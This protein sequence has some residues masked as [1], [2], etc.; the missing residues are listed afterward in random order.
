M[1]AADGR[2]Y[3]ELDATIASQPNWGG[4][5][6]NCVTCLH[7]FRATSD[8]ITNKTI[9]VWRTPGNAIKSH[10][11]VIVETQCVCGRHAECQIDTLN[12]CSKNPHSTL[13]L[14]NTRQ[15]VPGAA[16]PFCPD[17]MYVNT[18]SPSLTVILSRMPCGCQIRLQESDTHRSPGIGCAWPWA[19]FSLFVQPNH[20]S[21]WGLNQQYLAKC[22]F[23]A[24]L[25]KI[26]HD[27]TTC[28]NILLW[29][30]SKCHRNQH[31]W[32]VCSEPPPAFSRKGGASLFAS[33]NLSAG[34][35]QWWISSRWLLLI[36]RKPIRNRN[37]PLTRR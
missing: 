1:V 18:P 34:C 12:L 24:G 22:L 31:S 14:K 33:V 23:F 20:G 7:H 30:E 2:C 21:V 17:K 9:I 4:L 27:D 3:V 29:S 32:P 36:G 10:E 37:D 8:P 6:G 5:G 11:S 28:S 26:L 25:L 15:E 16:S 35:K 19:M 13:R